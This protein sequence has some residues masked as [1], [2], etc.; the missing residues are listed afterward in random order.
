MPNGSMAIDDFQTWAELAARVHRLPESDARAVL[1]AAGALGEWPAADARWCRYVVER[2]GDGDMEPAFLLSQLCADH[3]AARPVTR[4]PAPAPAPAPVASPPPAPL[5]VP[6]AT[7]PS[8]P[9]RSRGT[10][11]M[12]SLPSAGPWGAQDFR[13]RM[14]VA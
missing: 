11:E 8:T 2:I 14:S 7:P 5:P 6:S 12:P 9:R 1:E 13:H 4:A 10:Q 3:A